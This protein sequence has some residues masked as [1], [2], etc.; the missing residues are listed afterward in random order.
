MEK[1]KIENLD[2]SYAIWHESNNQKYLEIYAFKLM[3]LL[4][5]V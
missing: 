4:Y 5:V 1:Q 3:I 2:G